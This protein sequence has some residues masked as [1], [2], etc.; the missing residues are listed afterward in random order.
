MIDGL[1]Q[2]TTQYG[3]EV[4]NSKRFFNFNSID[5]ALRE[6]LPSYDYEQGILVVVMVVVV[7][8]VVSSIG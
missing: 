7:V 3:E 5:E 8:V 4:Q 2:G 1:K 6:D